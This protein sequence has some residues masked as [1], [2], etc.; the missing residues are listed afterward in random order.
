[1]PGVC[2][3]YVSGMPGIRQ[4][5]AWHNIIC[6]AHAWHMLGICKACARHMP[7]ICLACAWHMPGICQAHAWQMPGVCQVTCLAYTRHI[8]GTCQ[9]YGTRRN[10]FLLFGSI[11]CS[12]CLFHAFDCTHEWVACSCDDRSVLYS[13]CV[14]RSRATAW[15][16][17]I[18]TS[19]LRN[20]VCDVLNR[21]GSAN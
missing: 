17:H 21:V 5:C 13:A 1:M 15:T 8:P 16:R 18:A 11:S 14:N 3:A 20:L 9:A 12:T 19:F 2:Q 4:A 7:G 6:Q 10:H